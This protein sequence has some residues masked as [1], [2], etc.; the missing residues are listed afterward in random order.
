MKAAI[1]TKPGVIEVMEV[2][3]P[4]PGPYEVLVEVT[5]C[6][7][8]NGTDIKIVE[9][10]WPGV[11]PMPYILGH[12]A[13]GR[14]VATGSK[15]RNLKE[16]QIIIQPRVEGDPERGIGTAWGGFVE[17]A[18]AADWKAMQADGLALA[19][20]FVKAQQIVPPEM[21]P[22]D[23]IM[24]ITLKE[25]YS[26]LQGFGIQAG[27]DVLIYGDGPVG[28]CMAMCAR[29]MG[30]GRV[31]LSGHHDARLALAKQSGATHVIN[32]KETDLGQFIRNLAPEGLPLI[33]DAIGNNQVVQQGLDLIADEGHIGV[34]G[35]SDQRQA[36]LDWSRAPVRWSIDYLVVPQLDRL[37][38]AH[39]VLV[40]WIMDD[41]VNLKE[42]VTH[43]VPMDQADKSYH[44]TK[45]REALKVIVNM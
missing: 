11:D 41:R 10:H 3:D 9:G 25:V 23:A 30:A 43:Q 40:D 26:A 42:L 31:I 33:I 32:S 8:C 29:Q 2:S 22:A 14:V 45:G 5:G 24:L 27:M 28:I 17:K 39:A 36:T 15:V 35:Y 16:D 1:V 37:T 13:V 20:P 44:L 18:L 34:Y 38:A 19:N 12:E 7:F 4:E 21:D 6:G